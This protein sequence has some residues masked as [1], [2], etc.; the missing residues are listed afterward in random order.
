MDRSP[1]AQ[2]CKCCAKFFCNP[3]PGTYDDTTTPGTEILL[4]FPKFRQSTNF[5]WMMV[6]P[7]DNNVASGSS[8]CKIFGMNRLPYRSRRS[9]GLTD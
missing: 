2:S 5:Q 1:P 4:P 6:E 3:I 8:R 9:V 7:F